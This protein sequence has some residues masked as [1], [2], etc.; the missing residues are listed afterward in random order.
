M[1]TRVKST[2]PRKR[3][4]LAA[5][6]RAFPSVT[7]SKIT[8]VVDHGGDNFS[9]TVLQYLPIEGKSH[10]KYMNLGRHGIA[11][12]DYLEAKQA[13]NEEG[14]WMDEEAAEAALRG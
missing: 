5:F 12:E 6:R 4:V 9:A 2:D 13:E 7:I 10:G 8:D 1:K 14:R 11:R 3:I